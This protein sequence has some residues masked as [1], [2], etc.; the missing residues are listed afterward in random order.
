MAVLQAASAFAELIDGEELR[1][2]T[3]PFFFEV[4]DEPGIVFDSVV[5]PNRSSGSYAVT[6]VRI[7]S[8]SSMAIINE[9][10]VSLGDKIGD[11]TVVSIDRSG[12][13]LMVDDQEQRV[14]LYNTD[15]N[16]KAPAANR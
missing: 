5:L 6:F 3:R 4:A 8:S 9:Q 2:P 12:V 10:R 13:T 16:F 15:I 1:D 14:N 11:A 7:G